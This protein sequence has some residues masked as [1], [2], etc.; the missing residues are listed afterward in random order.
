MPANTFSST[1]DNYKIVFSDVS[2]STGSSTYWRM[3]AAGTDATA[4][5]YTYYWYYWVG[6]TGI[7][8][9]GAPTAAPQLYDNSISSIIEIFRPFSAVATNVLNSS[10]AGAQFIFGGGGHSLTTSYDSMSFI[11][12]SGTMTG[13]YSVYG[14][15]I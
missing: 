4:A 13:K 15:N 3:R 7:G 14:Y 9:S 2:H 11:R 1:Y 8:F 5:N 6:S 12:T 10:T